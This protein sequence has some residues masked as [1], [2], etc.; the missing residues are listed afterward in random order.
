MR[1]IGILL[2]TVIYL[3]GI[4]VI[5]L[6]P[7]GIVV[8]VVEANS[9]GKY[10]ECFIMLCPVF[11]AMCLAFGLS[12]SDSLLTRLLIYIRILPRL[13]EPSE[14]EQKRLYTSGAF[15]VLAKSGVEIENVLICDDNNIN[16]YAVGSKTVI[17]TSGIFSNKEILE[18]MLLGV[19]AHEAG[20]I[21]KGDSKILR[22]FYAFSMIAFIVEIFTANL[23]C[24]FYPVLRS[25]KFV[26]IVAWLIRGILWAILWAIRL[27]FRLL[28]KCGN[29]IVF[30]VLRNME[31]AADKYAHENH[32]DG[33]KKF[34]HVLHEMEKEME[35]ME[36]EKIEK[37]NKTLLMKKLS[38]FFR[39]PR[40]LLDTHPATEKRIEK[41]K[42]LDEE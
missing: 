41:L 22:M 21:S 34:L 12:K 37:E 19:A 17:F 3:A 26:Q 35:K 7:M 11:I 13:R 9:W 1:C 42:K 15:C 10:G 30:Y 20:H 8:R 24:F 27:L 23:I 29:L 6:V 5:S 39:L 28:L 25:Y 31:F 36:K 38:N 16:A 18:D 33:L 2:A 32:G 14:Y 40:N 4:F